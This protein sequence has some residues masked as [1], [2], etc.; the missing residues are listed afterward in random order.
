MTKSGE[1]ERVFLTQLNNLDPADKKHI[2]KLLDSFNHK[3]HL[4]LVFEAF[5]Q[6]LREANK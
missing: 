2:V 6:N 3:R 4:C 5:D 1:K